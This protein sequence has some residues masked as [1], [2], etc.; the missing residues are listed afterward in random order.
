MGLALGLAVFECA[1]LVLHE[2]LVP[3]QLS[4]I[5]KGKGFEEVPHFSRRHLLCV[6]FGFTVLSF[7]EIRGV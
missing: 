2:A 7:A 1:L 5:L 4:I 6:G 3:D